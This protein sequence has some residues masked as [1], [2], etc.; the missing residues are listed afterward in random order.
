MNVMVYLP[1]HLPYKSTK[2][3]QESSSPIDPMRKYHPQFSA[4]STSGRMWKICEVN[5]WKMGESTRGSSSIGDGWAPPLIGILLYRFFSTP[6]KIWDG[7]FFHT[8]KKWPKRKKRQLVSL[9]WFGWD[10]KIAG[11]NWIRGGQRVAGANHHRE[12]CP[13]RSQLVTSKK[14]RGET[15]GMAYEW[16]MNPWFSLGAEKKTRRFFRGRKK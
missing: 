16:P 15:T 7:V 8:T 10:S 5:A 3:I 1:L 9:T 4:I 13:K 11:P 14:S 2:C 12:R 6:I